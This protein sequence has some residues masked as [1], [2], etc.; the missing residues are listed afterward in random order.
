MFYLVIFKSLVVT[1]IMQA[2]NFD[3][4]STSNSCKF[5][6]GKLVRC[7]RKNQI[8]AIAN[9]VLKL[10]IEQWLLQ[11]VWFQRYERDWIK[12]GKCSQSSSYLHCL[13]PRV[14]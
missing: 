4:R 7:K 14:L 2:P 1:M 3:G 9:L 11:L 8:V 10:N 12:G 6:G 5:V 13:K